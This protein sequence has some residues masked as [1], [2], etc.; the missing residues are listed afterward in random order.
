MG[1]RNNSLFLGGSLMVLGILF[2]VGQ[3]LSINVWAVFWPLLLILAGLT[4]LLGRSRLF[5]TTGGPVVE[6]ALTF[7]APFNRVKQRGVGNLTLIQGERDELVIAAPEEAQSR[8]QA[9]VRD[10]CLTIRYNPWKDWLDFP[11]WGGARVD[12]RLTLR[13]LAGLSASGAGNCRC[14]ALKTDWL[15]LEHSG[16]GNIDFLGLEASSLKIRH[17]GAGNITVSGRVEAQ[18]VHYSGVGNYQAANLESKTTRVEH[19][20]VGNATVWASETLDIQH[21]GVGNLEYYGRPIVTQ[22]KS[23]VGNVRNLQK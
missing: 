23:G 4:L 13:D 6:K 22:R 7:E 11:F 16:A 12:F 2:L 21:S 9:E 20:G 5:V 14:E 18:E 19:S 15:E 3:F 17:S 8:I 1:R 10:G